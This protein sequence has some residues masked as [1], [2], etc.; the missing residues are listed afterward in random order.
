MLDD[1][2]VVESYKELNKSGRTE[3]PREYIDNLPQ[4]NSNITDLLRMAPSVQFSES[5]RSS[6]TG[7][8]IAPEEMSISGGKTYQNL[9][10]VDGI[11]NTSI[12]D[13]AGF[14]PFGGNSIGGHSQ[15][16]FVNSSIVDSM[17]LY[18]SNI[19]ASF[20]GFM[21]GVVD[22]KTRMPEKE[23]G[24]S[25]SYRTTR[26]EW[27]EIFFEGTPEDKYK[28][29]NSGVYT[30][31]PKFEKHFYD[32]SLDV[33]V[34]DNTGFLI[35]YSRSESAIPL[36]SFDKWKEQW[37]KS[38]NLF[39]KGVHNIDGSSYLELTTSYS[40]YESR[41]HLP[42][43]MNSELNIKSGGL[44]GILKY[45][46]EEGD[47][48]LVLSLDASATET[49]RTAP[50]EYKKWIASGSKPWG[51]LLEPDTD[52]DGN[53]DNIT[54][55]VSAEG[56]FGSLEQEEN[57]VNLKLDHTVGRFK[58]GGDHVISYGAVYSYIS[59]TYNR[60][61]NAYS[62]I[63]GRLNADVVC[64]G[65]TGTCVDGEQYFNQRSITPASY[66]EAR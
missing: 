5:Y 23:F 15:K 3:I 41:Y 36:K 45:V 35:F 28:F 33:P 50:N 27:A 47:S 17:T 1:V 60:S 52:D 43:T 2:D 56:G 21:G 18:D 63:E 10:M 29:E 32:L 66:V 7:G 40:P 64:N 19:P 14:T 34:T 54:S 25:I 58:L 49:S 24:G 11:N 46:Q 31:Q 57:A 59:G 37:R 13:P 9:F 30:K 48:R 39:I 55:G 4:G 51:Y 6:L 38:E 44:S 12:L 42:D 62:Y 53:P 20:G 61:E 22:I 8:E 65:D 16:L 26:S